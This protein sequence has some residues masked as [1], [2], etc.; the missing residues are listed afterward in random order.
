VTVADQAGNEL[1]LIWWN[2][3]DEPLPEA[4]FDLVCKLS[5]SDYQ[6]SPQMSAEWV[7]FR[8]SEAGRKDIERRQLEI[9]DL[10]D[11]SHPQAELSRLLRASPQAC[12]WGEGDL[13]PDLPFRGRHALE[14]TPHLI[15]W[16]IPP[17]QSVL[18]RVIHQT[19]PRR[20]TVFGL[21]PNLDALQ[22]FMT[23]LAGAAR[24]VI[25]QMGGQ[26][27]LE[28]LAGACAAAEGTVRIGLQLWQAQGKLQVSFDRDVVRIS[29]GAP[30]PDPLAI[31]ELTAVLAA[32]LEEARAYRGFF[33]QSDLGGLISYEGI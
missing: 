22:P 23:R 27:P 13:P 16:T 4:Q 8:L 19:Q 11:V 28:R 14:Q 33:R 20:V 7:D 29:D 5:R 10:R 3:G 32:L 1:R 12:V 18:R 21:D 30:E 9:V 31:E 6:G 25:H 24:Y 2:G 17:A 26:A 15:I